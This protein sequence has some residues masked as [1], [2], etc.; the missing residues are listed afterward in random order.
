MKRPIANLLIAIVSIA[1]I[2]GCGGSENDDAAETATA[3]DSQIGE[4]PE[5]IETQADVALKLQQG[6]IF[7][8]VKTVEQFLNQESGVS[9]VE[10][11]SKLTLM[12]Q[13]YVAEVRNG[14]FKLDVKYDSLQYKQRIGGRAIDYDSRL[15]LPIPDEIAGYAGMAKNGFSIWLDDRNT[16]VEVEG[17]E[18]FLAKCMQNIPPNERKSAI[19]RMAESTGDAHVANFID[20]SI[21]LLA[22]DPEHG[23]TVQLGEHWKKIRRLNQPVPMFFETTYTVGGLDTDT[24][25][26]GI[27][28]TIAP[29]VGS[30]GLQA[31]QPN[32]QIQLASGSSSG[33]CTI[34]RSTGLPIRSRVERNLLLMIRTQDRTSWQKKRIVTTI[35]AFPAQLGSQNRNPE[36]LP[37]SGE[38]S[39]PDSHSRG[40]RNY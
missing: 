36:I 27:N 22:F 30:A 32:V 13:I 33:S 37:V 3:I 1:F 15:G 29:G 14:R 10:N 4:I 9:S 16:V 31:Q 19:S 39:I 7:P 21:G 28:G 12:M 35:Q 11:A 26:I 25:E 5:E 40:S 23:P 20:D 34:R 17:F 24:I 18:E 6:D 8:M 38:R 2:A